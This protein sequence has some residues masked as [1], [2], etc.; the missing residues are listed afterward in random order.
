MSEH[1][2]GF[3]YEPSEHKQEYISEHLY[4]PDF[5]NPRHPSVLY[6]I[7]GIF[8]D[9]KEARKYKDVVKSNPSLEIVFI[10]S[11]AHQVVYP[12]TKKRKDGSRQ[13]LADWCLKNQFLWFEADK[14]HNDIICGKASI[15][16]VRQQKKD[17]GMI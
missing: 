3:E 15:Q 7:K 9:S 4:Q 11:N 13:T 1:L 10:F 12:G 8:E 5:V 2:V 6:E 14:I 16:W 17:R